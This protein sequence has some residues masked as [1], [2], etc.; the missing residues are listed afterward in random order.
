MFQIVPSHL[1]VPNIFWTDNRATL[2]MIPPVIFGPPGWKML[3][4]VLFG[5]NDKSEDQRHS[6]L[7]RWIYDYAEVLPCSRCRRN[8]R[9]CLRKYPPEKY[10][11]TPHGR[12]RWFRRVRAYVRKHESKPKYWWYEGKNGGVYRITPN[13]KRVYATVST[14]RS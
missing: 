9:A 14:G 12:R 2:R 7:V 3:E 11:T 5:W 13:G 8:F 4:H 10:V 1:N 6:V